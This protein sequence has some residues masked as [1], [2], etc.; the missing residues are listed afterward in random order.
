MKNFFMQ[1]FMS[2]A[3]DKINSVLLIIIIIWLLIIIINL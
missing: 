2:R 3:M 1:F